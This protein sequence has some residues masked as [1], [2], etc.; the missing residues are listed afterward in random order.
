LLA[1]AVLL[2]SYHFIS[3]ARFG[4]MDVMLALFTM[5]AAYGC[6]RLRAGA[7]GGRWWYLIWIAV[8]LA[9][10][11]KGAGGLV[12]PAVVV[13]ALLLDKRLGAALG[14][15]HFWMGCLLALLI[16]APW[17][18][19]MLA[20]YRREFVEEYVGY[21]VVARLTHP[22][23][24]HASGHL[25]YV[26]RLVD[27]FFPWVLL[28]PFA[29]VSD[30]RENLRGESR[31]RIFLIIAALVFVVYTLIP[32]RRPWYVVP[33]YPALAILVAAFVLRLYRARLL[34]PTHRR[35]FV[36][37]CV[38]LLLVGGAYTAISLRLNRNADAP[39]ARLSRLAAGA[40]ASDAEPL[41]LFSESEPFY[42]QT[43]LLY[44][45]RP[46]RQA[47]AASEPPGEDAKRYVDYERL[48]DVLGGET[49]RVILSRDD[50]ARLFAGYD[51]KVIAED[52][53]L[54]YATIKRRG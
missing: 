49:R 41:V 2:T 45:D 47:Y 5:L 39:L 43:A 52:A 4:T 34:R 18:A 21:H 10:M 31:S 8:A 25:Y 22:L 32:T 38:L 27:G 15:P 23:E 20:R 48:D 28:A 13:L 40:D 37:A 46:V 33:L 50:A 19:L 35:A 17:H 12:A 30:V 6:L 7:G 36:A 9:L 29:F 11:L 53:P 24:G 1:A 42:A 54:V 26:A 3:F 44:G 51:I 16:V 14:S